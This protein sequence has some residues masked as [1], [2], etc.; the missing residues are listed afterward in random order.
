MRNVDYSPIYDKLSSC[1]LYL[2]KHRE[3]KLKPFLTSSRKF[4]F[5]LTRFE[6]LYILIW[7]LLS[8]S[9][10]IF[11]TISYTSDIDLIGRQY[12]S[13]LAAGTICDTS[14]SIYSVMDTLS[15]LLYGINLMHNNS[16]VLLQCTSTIVNRIDLF[17]PISTFGS[18]F[19]IRID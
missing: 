16:F 19:R 3:E 5:G 9:G 1:S 4:C 12:Y 17:R 15:S 14:N 13:A 10:T 18:T 11:N 7:N 6:T 8:I 2:A